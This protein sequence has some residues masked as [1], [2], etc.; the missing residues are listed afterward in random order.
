MSTW[1][2][3]AAQRAL[4]L[5]TRHAAGCPECAWFAQLA[6]ATRPGAPIVAPSVR[7]PDNDRM[8]DEQGGETRAPGESEGEGGSEGEGEG[9]PE[10]EPRE[11]SELELRLRA[12]LAAGKV[13]EAVA[14][15]R[16]E[17]GAEL[18]RFVRHR[19]SSRARLGVED[20]CQEVWASAHRGLPSFRFES[21]PRAWL[22]AIAGRRVID[23]GRMGPA[24][25][26]IDTE[27]QAALADSLTGPL[28]RLLRDERIAAVR[29]VLGRCDP[30]DVE[31]LHLRFALDLMPQEIAYLR[32]EERGEPPERPNT[33][34]QRIGRLLVK[35]GKQL[36]KH[37]L[38]GSKLHGR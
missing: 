36:S 2:C 9:G 31:L 19:R 21:T 10:I 20:L 15:L 12:L 33:I 35:L 27:H 34:A 38:F 7:R 25:D 1:R 26:A 28:S 4:T 18:E 13:G 23:V 29:E 6:G 30:D 3:E 22:Y 17:Y 32:A 24:D 16:E 37:S 11:P 5:G 14:A 8:P